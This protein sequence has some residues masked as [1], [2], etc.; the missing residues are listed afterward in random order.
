LTDL[1]VNFKDQSDEVDRLY[2]NILK[3]FPEEAKGW[4][5]A[6]KKTFKMSDDGSY[7]TD[8]PISPLEFYKPIVQPF[9]NAAEQ[10]AQREADAKT[11]EDKAV[12]DAEI[13]AEQA[14]RGDLGGTAGSA[15]GKPNPLAD[16]I[17][18]YLKDN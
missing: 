9:V 17:T 16:A 2:G 10:V 1:N 4:L 12:K 14:D 5:E 11:A 7:V 6:Y 18:N 15:Q 8:V 3:A 13:A